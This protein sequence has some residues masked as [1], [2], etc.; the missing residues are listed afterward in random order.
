MNQSQ[1]NRLK[2]L[3]IFLEQ[4]THQYIVNQSMAN[5]KVV[6]EIAA[7]LGI[8]T[9]SI[10]CSSC[11]LKVYQRVAEHFFEFKK[12]LETKSSKSSKSKPK[13]NPKSND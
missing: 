5:K 12:S 13:S 7:E 8:K 2:P 11:V 4:S 10:S 9:G 6:F 1:F 3:E